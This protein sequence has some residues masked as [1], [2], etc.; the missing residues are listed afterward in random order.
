MQF[1]LGSKK[2]EEAAAAALQLDKEKPG[3]ACARFAAD[4]PG[5]R[6][7]RKISVPLFTEGVERQTPPPPDSVLR[8]SKGGSFSAA[9]E[10]LPGG[11]LPALPRASDGAAKRI[12]AYVTLSSQC[13]R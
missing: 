2:D 11:G 10:A 4:I 9:V 12:A 3:R 6:A 13:Q 8:S 5:F 7:I 1:R